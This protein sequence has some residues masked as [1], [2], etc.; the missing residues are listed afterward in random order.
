MIES[1]DKDLELAIDRKMV[2]K[3]YKLIVDSLKRKG[4]GVS[5]GE[6]VNKIA[7]DYLTGVIDMIEVGNRYEE[8]ANKSIENAFKEI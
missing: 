7:A 3:Q 6:E 4:I 5:L 8:A 1:F 2:E